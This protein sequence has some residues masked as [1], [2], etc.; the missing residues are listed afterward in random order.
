MDKLAHILKVNDGTEPVRKWPAMITVLIMT[1]MVCLDSSIVTVAL[2]VMREELGVGIADIQWVTTTYLAATCLAVLF[3]G[4]MGDRR[5]KVYIF[6]LGVAVFTLGSLL[7]GMSPTLGVLVC[8]RAVQ[9]LGCAAAMANNMGIITEIFPSEERG[10]AMGLLATFVALGMM[11]GPVLGG[12]LVSVFPWESIFLINVPVGIAAFLAGLRTLPHVRPAADAPARRGFP[13]YVFRSRTFTLNFVTMLIAFVA[14]G[15]VEFSI[16]FFLQD[17]QGLDAATASLVFV[18]LPA[19]NTFVG[20]A[21]G[22][23]SDRVGGEVL[24][25]AGMGVYVVALLH[26]A[27]L[28]ETAPLA[29][30][31]ASIAFVSLGTSIFQAPNNSLF[32][33]AAPAEAL[34]FAGS[35]GSL[36]RYFGLGLGTMGGSAVLYAQMSAAAGYPVSAYVEGRPDIFLYGYRSLFVLLAALAVVA[37]AITVV[38]LVRKRKGGK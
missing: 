2:P 9:G 19:V 31:V 5:G 13:L 32:M 15:A 18:A 30:V 16:P 37:L 38:G 14:I 22:S 26:M 3:F 28:T 33:G 10:R 35:L 17:A 11:A 25:V 29:L 23:L 8:A 24:T 27:T 6:Q 36:A 4:Q 1:F 34:G 21:S 7:C 20:P 12:M